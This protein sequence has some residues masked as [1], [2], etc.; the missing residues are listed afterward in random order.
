MEIQISKKIR[1]NA[2]GAIIESPSVG[3][4]SDSDDMPYTRGEKTKLANLFLSEFF[5][6]FFVTLDNGEPLFDD[7]YNL[8]VH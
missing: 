2:Y 4:I 3:V 8:I 1:D 7:N 6:S 5:F